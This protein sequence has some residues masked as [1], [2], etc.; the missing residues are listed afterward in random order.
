M[1][2]FIVPMKHAGEDGIYVC[3]GIAGLTEDAYSAIELSID[4]SEFIP[5]ERDA[6]FTFQS[7]PYSFP[8]TQ[9]GM[10]YKVTGRVVYGEQTSYFSSNIVSQNYSQDEAKDADAISAG[11]SGGVLPPPPASPISLE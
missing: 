5:L 2:E 6:D 1:F 3:A 4:G 11:F 7:K 10:V 9:D 8:V